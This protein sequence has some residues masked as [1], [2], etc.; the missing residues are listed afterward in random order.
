MSD[1]PKFCRDCRHY[2]R[3]GS[4]EICYAPP[5]Q[6]NLVTGEDATEFADIRRRG[7]CGTEARLFAAKTPRPAYVEQHIHP[8]PKA[9]WEFWR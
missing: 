9:W 8:Q 2:Q 3:E 7:I 5:R 6:P 4:F 1:A